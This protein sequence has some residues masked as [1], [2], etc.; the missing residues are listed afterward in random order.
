MPKIV[1]ASK[2]PIKVKATLSGFQQMFQDYSFEV[3][4]VEVDSGV[5]QQP[6]SET[7]TIQGSLN[8]IKNIKELKPEADF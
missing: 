3:E 7:E 2:N 8:R 1:I 5:S 4:G 6:I